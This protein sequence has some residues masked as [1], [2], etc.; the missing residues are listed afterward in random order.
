MK[1]STRITY[2]ITTVLVSVTQGILPIFSTHSELTVEIITH[3]GY[4]LYFI[5][6]LNIFKLLGGLVLLIPFVPNR[7]KEWAYAGFT[8]DFV[9]AFVSL[10]V[11][12]GLTIG[13]FVPV[14]TLAFLAASY[15]TH[16]KIVR[17][18]VAPA[19]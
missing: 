3:L 17:T 16:H 13:T 5:L 8:F 18:K 11:V 15:I 7:L 2:W 1:K 19:L 9:A 14:V 10:L 12:D 4:P 6:M